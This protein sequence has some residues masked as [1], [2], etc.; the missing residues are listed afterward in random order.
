MSSRNNYF[1]ESQRAQAAMLYKLLNNLKNNI[2]NNSE[3]VT[4][5]NK[6]ILDSKESFKN[7]NFEIDYIEVRSNTTLNIITDYN[8]IKKNSSRLFIACNFYGVRL[9]D[10]IN[11]Q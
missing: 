3:N 4:N 5:I 7:N 10:N 8:S 9:I 11:L 6:Y 2:I 1:S